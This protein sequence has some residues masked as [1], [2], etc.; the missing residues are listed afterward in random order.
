MTTS[1][2]ARTQV[3]SPI[4]VAAIA[5]TLDLVSVL[6]FAASGRSS[7]QHGLTFAGILQTAWPFLAALT[8]MWI[9]TLA[10][11]RPTAPLRTGIP[12][13]IGTVALGM[14]LRV[15][16]TDGE[17]PTAFVI[18]ASLVLGIT[19]V[20]WR[21]LWTTFRRARRRSASGA[22]PATN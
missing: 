1:A 2:P 9:L 11:T 6:A 3:R 16:F 12:I 5:A 18:V 14:L 10:V 17:A 22:D 8:V 19:L 20:G 15:L 21:G 13:W 4:G 7:H